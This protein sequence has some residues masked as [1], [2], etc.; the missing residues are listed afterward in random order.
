MKR[1]KQECEQPQSRSLAGMTLIE[2]VISLAI[3]ALAVG[4][5]IDGYIYCTTSAQKAA[6]SLAGS[7]RAMERLEETRSAKWDMSSWPPVDQLDATNFPDEVVVLDL[8]GSRTATNTATIQTYI[9]QVSTNPP[10]K[11]IHV[12]CVWF[13]KGNQPVT[14]SIETLRAPDQ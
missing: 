1:L 11:R 4:A 7:A 13:F 5:I 3:A 6:L 9:T 2:V 12:D 10:F 8:S 14:N